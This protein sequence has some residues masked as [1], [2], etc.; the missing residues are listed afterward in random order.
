MDHN[1][2]LSKRRPA[3]RGEIEE[4]R[5]VEWQTR[6]AAPSEFEN[7]LGDALERAFADGAATLAEVVAHLNAQG[8]RDAEGQAWSE[9]SFQAQMKRLGG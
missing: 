1:P 6:A 3:G 7:R 9:A 5:N 4:P 2:F 8:S